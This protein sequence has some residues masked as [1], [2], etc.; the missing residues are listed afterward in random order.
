LIEGSATLREVNRT[1]ELGLPETDEWSTV[2]GLA[3][4]LA[5]RIPAKGEKFVIPNG[6]TLEIVDASPR[7]VRAVRVTP[8]A[9]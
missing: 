7:R 8:Q 9:P 3:V 6:P 5:R 1:L 4:G 2:A